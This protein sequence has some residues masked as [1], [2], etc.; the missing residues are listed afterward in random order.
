MKKNI[1]SILLIICL[2]FFGMFIFFNVL[3][4]TFT[5]LIETCKENGYD[6]F[7]G[8]SIEINGS[9]YTKCSKEYMQETNVSGQ[10]KIFKEISDYIKIKY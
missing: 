2:L 6:T 7:I 3:K 1:K 5:P 9:I 8:S 10:Y 4:I